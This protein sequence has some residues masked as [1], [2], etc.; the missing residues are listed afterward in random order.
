MTTWHN[1]RGPS[2]ADQI[3]YSQPDPVDDLLAEI[4]APLDELAAIIGPA[5]C[6]DWQRNN[7]DIREP[8]GDWVAKVKAEVIIRRGIVGEFHQGAR[9]AR[10][11]GVK[12]DGSAEISNALHWSDDPKY[13]TG[14]E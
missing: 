3:A 9:I 1:L 8:W 10:E 12:V 14:G 4:K 5:A 13:W 2:A 6:K 11:L 7:F